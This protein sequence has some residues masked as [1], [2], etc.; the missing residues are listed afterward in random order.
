MTSTEISTDD[1]AM[2]D[3]PVVT[4]GGTEDGDLNQPTKGAPQSKEEDNDVDKSSTTATTAPV[5]PGDS[6]GGNG[7]DEALMDGSVGGVGGEDFEECKLRQSSQGSAEEFE[8]ENFRILQTILTPICLI[9]GTLIYGTILRYTR[10]KR[11]VLV[12][13]SVWIVWVMKMF[14]H[15]LQHYKLNV[16]KD[17]HARL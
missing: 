5:S 17:Y 9:A 6:G 8:T 11:E 10:E 15:I 1:D 7:D 13:A 4:D 12:I 3:S 2:K 16:P 14:T